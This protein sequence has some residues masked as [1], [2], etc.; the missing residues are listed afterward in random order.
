MCDLYTYANAAA[1]AMC[2][3][4]AG[5]RADERANRRSV[6]NTMVIKCSSQNKNDVIQNIPTTATI[7]C[8]T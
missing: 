1:F 3:F 8:T 2:G 5:K 7:L 6:I 4:N